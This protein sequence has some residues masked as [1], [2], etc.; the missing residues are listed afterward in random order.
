MG[1]KN[2][3]VC[4][5]VEDSVRAGVCE[6]LLAGKLKEADAAER[7]RLSVRQV[8]RLKR[9]VREEGPSGVVHRLR[10]EASGR[11]TSEEVRQEVV[12]LYRE[13]YAG[14]NMVHF[15]EYL[16][17]RHKIRL[18]SETLRQVLLNAES[19]PRRRHRSRHRQWRERR[20]CEAELVQMDTSI[21]AWLGE[22]G[23]SVVLISA[24]DDATSRILRAEFFEHN[25]VL[26]N[27]T[28]VRDLVATYGL[29]A[30]LYTDHHTIFFLCEE[31]ALAA[32]ERGEDGLTQFGRVMK[33]LGIEMI[34]AGSPQAKGRVERSYRTL[35]DRLL[36]E[37]RLEGI[38]TRSAA[39]GYLR[40]C[41]IPKYNRQFGVEPAQTETAWVDADGI[42]EHD[43]F[44]LRDTRVVQNDATISVNGQTWQL[45]GRVRSGQKVELRT[46]LDGTVHVFKGDRE[47]AYH[48]VRKPRSAAATC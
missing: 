38:R 40:R 10:G 16:G 2:R 23:E 14:W 13:R 28:V 37:L 18:S 15:S 20:R 21:H 11:R 17:S 22:D 42:D 9:R 46:W 30:S 19:R 32:R 48:P 5:S 27:L 12:R 25:G 26:E 34:P 3:T 36:K 4:M 7:L 43:V 29:P 33:R 31:D 41:F 45:E 24:V 35:Q 44:C 8:R 1:R 6:Q 47:I 39:N